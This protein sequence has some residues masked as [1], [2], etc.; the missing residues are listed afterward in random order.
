MHLRV[1]SLSVALVLLAGSSVACGGAVTSSLL[2]DQD[3]GSRDGATDAPIHDGAA[4]D[5][6]ADGSSQDAPSADATPPWSPDCPASAPAV[7]SACTQEG[8]QCEYGDAW[9]S[10]S[11]DVVVECDGGQWS[12]AQ[13]DYEPCSPQPGPNSS[14]CPATYGDVPQGE[15]P[16]DGLVCAYAQGECTCQV[17]LGPIEIDGGTPDWG[18]LPGDGC[19]FPRPRLG[20][21]CPTEGISCTYEACEYG[22]TCMGGV[23]QSEEEGCAEAMSGGQQ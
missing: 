14:Q 10:V 17:P 19:P 6:P 23:W 1:V 13:V 21:S 16:S 22:E 2:G 11:C 3:A 20:T 5:A 4:P 7:D 9:W 15:C 8:L 18:C 12:E